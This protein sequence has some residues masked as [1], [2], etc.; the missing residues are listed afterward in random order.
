MVVPAST[1]A[2]ILSWTPKQVEQWLKAHKEESKKQLF[3][4]LVHT[5]AIQL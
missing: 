2:K 3:D 1:F 5:V 4:I